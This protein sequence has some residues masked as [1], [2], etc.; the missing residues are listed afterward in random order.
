VPDFTMHWTRHNYATWLRREP[1]NDTRKLMDLGR[2]KDVRS[3][4]RYQHVASHEQV[5]ALAKLPLDA[6]AIA[7]ETG[8]LST[9]PSVWDKRR[10]AGRTLG[11]HGTRKAKSSGGSNA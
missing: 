1:G 7:A 9:Q 3:V 2:W 5:A 11:K 4:M 8:A 6:G 10:A